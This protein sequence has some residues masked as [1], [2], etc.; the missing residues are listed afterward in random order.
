MEDRCLKD[1]TDTRVLQTMVSGNLP[2]LGP[3]D[4]ECSIVVPRWSLGFLKAVDVACTHAFLFPF[5]GEKAIP[6]EGI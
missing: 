3:L 6:S 5:Q 1:H 4:E 2:G